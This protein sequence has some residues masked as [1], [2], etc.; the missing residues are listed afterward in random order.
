MLD[1]RIQNSLNLNSFLCPRH[2]GVSDYQATLNGIDVT[3][4][5]FVSDG[6]YKFLVDNLEEGSYALSLKVFFNSGNY[7]KV[8]QNFIV[9]SSAPEFSLL[10][11]RLDSYTNENNIKIRAEINDEISGVETDSIRCYVDGKDV[12]DNVVK[13]LNYVDYLLVD[14]KE[15]RHEIQIE[16]SDKYGNSGKSDVWEFT[17]DRTPPKVDIIIPESPYF[18]NQEEISV[19]GSVRDEKILSV[20]HENTEIELDS[21]GNFVVDAILTEGLNEFR[22]SSEDQAGNIGTSNLFSVYRISDEIAAVTAYV[23][24]QNSVPLSGIKITESRTGISTWTDSLGNFVLMDVPEG[25]LQLHISPGKES[26]LLPANILVDS[27]YGKAIVVQN[28]YL[29]SRPKKEDI[30]IEETENDVLYTNSSFP[31]L[32]MTINNS[33]KLDFPDGEEEITLA[34]VPS[35]QLPYQVPEFFPKCQALS[36]GPSGLKV[37]GGE[38][39]I[40]KFP[41]ELDLP[42]KERVLLICIDGD[43]GHLSTA[44]IA[45]VTEDGK[46][47]STIEGHGL[48]HFSTVIPLPVGAQI[49]PIREDVDVPASD[50]LKGAAITQLEFPSF[51]ILNKK[52]QPRLVYSSLAAAPNVQMTSIFRGMREINAGYETI[53]NVNINKE[54]NTKRIEFFAD[55]SL[56]LQYYR[57]HKGVL[58]F[59][60]K[61]D[62]VTY[63]FEPFYLPENIDTPL[64][65]TPESIWQKG[66][67][68][69]LDQLRVKEWHVNLYKIDLSLNVHR[70]TAV[71]PES[72]SGQCFF[73]DLDSGEF[74]IEGNMTPIGPEPMPGEDDNR[75]S[76]PRLP[77]DMTL[78]YHIE[79]RLE[80]GS[81]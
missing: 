17:V 14:A 52:I 73:S 60:R 21:D 72:I 43:S 24:D 23:Y 62:T 16:A 5:V 10:Y 71:W 70:N 13:S 6:E 47:I 51:R 12:T 76:H 49:E 53:E 48:L 64:L 9:D 68:W 80:D 7:R 44:G 38:K 65:V 36:L 8:S 69:K 18:T 35:W 74:T 42:P 57:D 77:E 34:M 15:G 54:Q 61:V 29:L 78:T 39:I 81:Y 40:I 56:W 58:E 45:E 19:K 31:D 63:H 33:T 3:D 20:R 4:Q 25:K 55:Y 11:P 1:K 32:E 22:I 46:K 2:S 59:N 30:V 41:N 79:P 28:I 37:K 66:H 26:D 27:E 50:A 75:E 67:E